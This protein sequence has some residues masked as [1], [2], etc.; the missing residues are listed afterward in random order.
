M[1]TQ[2]LFRLMRINYMFSEIVSKILLVDESKVADD[3]KRAD[4]ES[5]DSMNHLILIS[6]LEQNYNITFN[7]DDIASNGSIQDLKTV[8]KKYNVN[9]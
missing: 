7:D 4:L 3:L 5:W 6:E 1:I 9:V 2:N 8:L